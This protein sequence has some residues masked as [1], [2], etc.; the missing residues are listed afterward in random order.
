MQHLIGLFKQHFK[1]KMS[2][3]GEEESALPSRQCTGLH[4]SGTDG[5]I[6]PIPLRIASPSSIFAR[7][8]PVRLFP[9]SK[10]EEMV[11]R[12]EIHHQRA[13]HRRNR[14]LF[15]RTNHIIRTAW[16]SWRIVGSNISSWKETILR[17][18]NESFKKNVF[19]YNIFLKTY[20]LALVF[21]YIHK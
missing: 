1:E 12:K 10:P 9:V 18:K 11:R 5:K 15:W 3:F 2:P 14:G 4:V 7:F 20:W 19:Y 6:Q 8:S 16:K 17:N 13:A 21:F